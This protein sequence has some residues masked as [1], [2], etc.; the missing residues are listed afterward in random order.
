MI[1]MI[2]M[3]TLGT[4]KRFPFVLYLLPFLDFKI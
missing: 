1:N 2:N 3:K 4:L